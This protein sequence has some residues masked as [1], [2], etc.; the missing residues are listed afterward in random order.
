MNLHQ[1][2]STQLMCAHAEP[3]QP[4]CSKGTVMS[5]CVLLLK[6]LKLSPQIHT[7]SA[8]VHP[9][10]IHRHCS[11]QLIPKAQILQVT[12]ARAHI[13]LQSSSADT[14]P[15]DYMVHRQSQFPA[16]S[17]TH[18]LAV[19]AP[20]SRLL[21]STVMHSMIQ[22]TYIHRRADYHPRNRS[23]ATLAPFPLLPT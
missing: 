21:N 11:N 13:L 19:A 8:P 5:P 12:P 17:T 16:C 6:T 18:T 14:H 10:Q 23:D 3:I 9:S 22:P 2:T 15:I 4:A 20:D 1:T 7:G